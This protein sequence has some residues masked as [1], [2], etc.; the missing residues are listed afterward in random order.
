MTKP[1]PAE[2]TGL[3]RESVLEQL[4]KVL[5]SDI[6]QASERSAKLL[7]FM[8]VR[9]LDGESAS[10]K[11]YTLGADALGK[12]SSFDPRID[13]IVR[14][15]VSRLRGRLEKYYATEGKSDAVFIT[16]V[17]GS[18]VPQFRERT[19]ADIPAAAPSRDVAPLRSRAALFA[20]AMGAVLSVVLAIVLF[21]PWGAP[22]PQ[23]TV[24][25]AVLPFA[26]LSNDPD[27]DFFSDGVTDDIGAALAK[28]AD[29]SV[30]ARQSAYRFRD[31]REDARAIGQ[32]LGATHL[33]TGSVRKSGQRI[34]INAELVRAGD[35]LRV[36]TQTYDRDLT[37]VF[38]IQEDIAQS[39]A[40]S[41]SAP[42]GMRPGEILVSNRAKDE[43]SYEAY[44]RA[45][46]LIRS[47]QLDRINDAVMLLEQ[48]VAR[49]PDYAPA[50]A[51]L[52]TAHRFVDRLDP[53]RLIGA[54]ED[55]RA[56]TEIS[57]AKA[58]MASNRAVM[59]D[60]DGVDGYYA[61]ASIASVRWKHGPGMELVKKTLALDPEHP[62]ALNSYSIKLAELGYLKQAVDVGEH[63]Q[64]IEPYVPAFKVNFAIILW[65]SGKTE[66]AFAMLPRAL[67]W[68]FAYTAARFYASQGRFEEAANTIE[69]FDLDEP[70]L[71]PIRDAAIR[72][73]RAASTGAPSP[74]D[75]PNLGAGRWLHLYTDQPERALE[76]HEG[77]LK[78]G[79]HASIEP[80]EL[81]GS[82]FRAIR[83]TERFKKFASD[84]G[85]VDYWRAN[86]WPDLC[87]PVGADDFMCE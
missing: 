44:L 68:P 28:I 35:G 36:W 51:L 61:L 62:D 21:N 79:S 3:S 85:F 84:A 16:L 57:L 58:E 25:V 31:S 75:L 64:A 47:R 24:S 83:K 77:N 87:R 19:R 71:F 27:Q 30:I 74:H 48:T 29:L 60:P 4:E 59:L 17:K 73:L 54:A 46:A 63:L 23:D 82:S 41:L 40:M 14:P 66:S 5:A 2:A 12:G 76:Y 34:R 81:W 18:Y 72:I 15:E 45:K 70:L 56:I 42:L 37:D 80:V 26:N 8:V 53:I 65:V 11:E 6:F 86:G 50:W 33:I 13:T 9:T 67:E 43:Q 78:L 38:G 1:R 20:L 10:L 32:A 49:D 52:G 7:R 69:S 55:A 39:I 22:A